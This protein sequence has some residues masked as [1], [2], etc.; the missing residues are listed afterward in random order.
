VGVDDVLQ[1]LHGPGLVGVRPHHPF[2]LER[3][4]ITREFRSMGRRR[5]R[6]VEL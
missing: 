6:E 2:E 1:F 3:G 5:L 4:E